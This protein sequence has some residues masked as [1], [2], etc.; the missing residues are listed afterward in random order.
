MWSVLGE[1]QSAF[2]Y[3]CVQSFPTNPTCGPSL[4]RTHRTERDPRACADTVVCSPR[5]CSPRTRPVNRSLFA[6]RHA[7]HPDPH[8]RTL[9]GGREEAVQV[10]RTVCLCAAHKSLHIFLAPPSLASA[11]SRKRGLG[12]AL[13]ARAAVGATPEIVSRKPTPC[14]SSL[15]ALPLPS[16]RTRP[17]SHASQRPAPPIQNSPLPTASSRLSGAAPAA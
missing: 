13:A 15:S 8:H 1:S 5:V 12:Q 3:P 16:C 14:C 17:T 2:F 9:K 4:H 10:T 7:N 11:A 6:S